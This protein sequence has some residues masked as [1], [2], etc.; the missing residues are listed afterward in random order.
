MVLS[1]GTTSGKADVMAS[2]LYGAA[3]IID[4]AVDGVGHIP[5]DVCAGLF[6]PSNITSLNPLWLLVL[7]ADGEDSSAT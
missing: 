3:S 1:G 2:I 5:P 7:T 6:D 4:V